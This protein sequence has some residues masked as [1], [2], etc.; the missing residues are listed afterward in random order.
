MAQLGKGTS[1]ANVNGLEFLG[2]MLSPGQPFD[3]SGALFELDDDGAAISGEILSMFVDPSI[4]LKAFKI[5]GK[6]GNVD[7]PFLG[8]G[9]NG[10]EATDFSGSR[11]KPLVQPKYQPGRNSPTKI[12]GRTYTGHALDQMQNRGI[13]PSVVEDAVSPGN[14]VAPGNRANTNIYYNPT[15][16]V[17]VITYDSGD[18]VTVITAPRQ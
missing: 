4:F 9:A 6:V 14:F 18:V 7:V 8:R 13:P 12:G 15:N 3:L 17:R 16:G 1:N 11:G 2:N 10:G 5:L